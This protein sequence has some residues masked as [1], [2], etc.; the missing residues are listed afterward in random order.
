MLNLWSKVSK[1]TSCCCGVD[2]HVSFFEGCPLLLTVKMLDRIIVERLSN[3]LASPVL[4]DY[5]LHALNRVS[6]E[7]SRSVNKVSSASSYVVD[8]V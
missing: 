1:R 4:L 8:C 7:M 6:A 2:V 5:L 3:E